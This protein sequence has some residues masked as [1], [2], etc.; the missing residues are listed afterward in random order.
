M[1]VG[2]PPQLL[3]KKKSM[4]QDH[5][6]TRWMRGTWLGKDQRTQEHVIAVPVNDVVKIVRARSI[7]TFA[8]DEDKWNAEAVLEIRG[9][10][11]R[12]QADEGE[13]TEGA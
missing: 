5:L 7:R 4:K 3:S 11:R 13:N 1:F 6:K 9:R 2:L 8:R 10:P 12:P